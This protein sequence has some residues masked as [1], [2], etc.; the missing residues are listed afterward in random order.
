MLIDEASNLNV[1]YGSINMKF[2]VETCRF[3]IPSTDQ[4]NSNND[5]HTSKGSII[6]EEQH[7]ALL[8]APVSNKN[9]ELQDLLENHFSLYDTYKGT[10]NGSL[11]QEFRKLF[12]SPKHL[13]R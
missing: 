13:L 6:N 12:Y 10:M 1:D 3:L 8:Q 5:H 2:D 9:L 7:E 11:Q 4:R